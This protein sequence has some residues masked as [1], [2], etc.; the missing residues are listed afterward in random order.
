[1]P[2]ANN[3]VAF[4]HSLTQRAAAVQAN[5]VHGAVCAVDVGDADRFCAAGK[6]LGF[7]DGREVRIR[8]V[9]FVNVGMGISNS[10]QLA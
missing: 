9:S 2:R 8:V 1:M 10:W 5:V 7:V 3:L 6:F 4:N